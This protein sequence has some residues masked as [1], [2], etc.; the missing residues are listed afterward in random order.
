MR[1]PWKIIVVV[2]A[3][4]AMTV[5]AT[6]LGFAEELTGKAKEYMALAEKYKPTGQ[7]KGAVEKFMTMDRSQRSAAKQQGSRS[8]LLLSGLTWLAMEYGAYALCFYAGLAGSDMSAGAIT[9]IG[10]DCNDKWVN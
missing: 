10:D 8:P 3:T 2:G 7:T 6:N 5:A 4:I 1:K 9:A